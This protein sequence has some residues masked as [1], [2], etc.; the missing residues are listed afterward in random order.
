MAYGGYKLMGGEKAKK[1]MKQAGYK[2]GGHVKMGK[3]EETAMKKAK[4]D[5]KA[6][7]DGGHVEDKAKKRMDRKKPKM[8]KKKDGGGVHPKLPGP[9]EAAG[10]KPVGKAYAK[11]GTVKMDAGAGGG[12]GRLEKIKEYGGSKNAKAMK[13]GGKC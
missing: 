6:Y 2:H 10:A 12:K 7:K 3:E 9:A 4:T 8:M 11:G 5:K 13:K 1:V